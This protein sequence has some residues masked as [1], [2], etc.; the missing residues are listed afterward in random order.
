MADVVIFG[1][2]DKASLAHFYLTCDSPHTVAAFTVDREFLPAERVFEGLP[3]VPFDELEARFPTGDFYGFAPLS[4]QRMNRD[5]QSVYERFKRKGYK[6][7]SY[8]STRVTCFPGTSI[9]D[10]C[11]ILEDNT[12]QPFVQIGNNVVLWSGNHVG[13]HSTIGDHVFVT[14]HV[15]LSG[16]S[17]VGANC[18]FGVNATIRDRLT[19]AEGT[20]VGMGATLVRDTDPW[21]VLKG[22]PAKPTGQSSLDIDF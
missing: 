7:I 20:L 5:R 4:Q 8:V 6:L 9:G 21:S 10:N 11:F 18:F 2:R 1:L 17:R 14:S 19:I 15:V 3:V 13:H 12:I 22:T 16:H